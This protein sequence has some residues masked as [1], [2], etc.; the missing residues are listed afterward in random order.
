MIEVEIQN[1]NI[2]ETESD[3]E[4]QEIQR[5]FNKKL[6]LTLIKFRQ[7]LDINIIDI[8][9]IIGAEV[10]HYMVHERL[11]AQSWIGYHITPRGFNWDVDLQ[12]VRLPQ[13]DEDIMRRDADLLSL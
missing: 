13:L 6:K 1:E 3:T 4:L 7:Q 11:V 5:E 10:L 9:K 8:N 12:C 2:V